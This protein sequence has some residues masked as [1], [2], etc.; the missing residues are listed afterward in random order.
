MLPRLDGREVLQRLRNE[1]NCN[2]P[3]LMLTARDELPDKIAGF[4]A[5]ADD[6]L[7]K[8]FALPELEVRLE[9]L[10]VRATGRG[11]SR[12]LQVGDLRCDLTTLEVT[13]K[14]RCCTC[15]RL[16]GSCWRC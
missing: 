12:V 11:R 7:T 2:V 8:P 10:V 16:A 13:R 15:S 3:V 9:A 5:G 1:A 4:R 14:G 6:Y